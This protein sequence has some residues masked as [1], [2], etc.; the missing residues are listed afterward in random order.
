MIS[1]PSG[2]PVGDRRSVTND[3]ATAYPKRCA[4]T[5][6][7]VSVP[8]IVVEMSVSIPLTRTVNVHAV[9]DPGAV[10]STIWRPRKYVAAI[11]RAEALPCVG[12]HTPGESTDVYSVPSP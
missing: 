1:A 10:S 5:D 12:V 7:S 6:P 3:P 9:P 11:H 2:F 4:A 8:L